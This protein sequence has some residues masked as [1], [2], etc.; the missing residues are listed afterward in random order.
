MAHD[1]A[2]RDQ[3]SAPD[4]EKEFT[5]LGVLRKGSSWRSTTL[6]KNFELCATYPEYLV[7]P[8]EIDDATLK[9]AADFRSKNRVP[10]LTWMDRETGAALCRCSQPMGGPKKMP[11]F[12]KWKLP[13]PN[14]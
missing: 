6:N 2:V 10:A 3:S 4:L 1:A 12:L 9:A 7:V 11:E 8:K 13:Q 14:C 5:R